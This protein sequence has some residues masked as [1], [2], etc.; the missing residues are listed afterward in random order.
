LIA[1]Q[2]S[3]RPHW[4]ASEEFADAGAP[5]ATRPDPALDTALGIGELD[6]LLEDARSRGFLDGH[7]AGLSQ[8]N[9]DRADLARQAMA[10]VV[11]ALADADAAHAASAE[12][13]ADTL[14]G[15]LLGS[16]ASVLPAWCAR[17]GTEEI[18]TLARAVVPALHRRPDVTI[19]IHPGVLA[20]LDAALPTLPQ[21]L[22]RRMLLT[23]CDAIAPGDAR[24]SWLDGDAV[25]TATRDA[26]ATWARAMAVLAECG[27]APVA[28]PV[29]THKPAMRELE[30]LELA[31]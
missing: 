31:A 25:G 29:P 12:R 28:T 26:A 27:L 14:A 19:E 18:A 8:A 9:A 17:H 20:A 11:A 1:I 13:A 24:L 16:L 5:V 4:F 21:A 2:T 30:V 3:S 23:P 15:L 10:A 6:G 7:A 22:R